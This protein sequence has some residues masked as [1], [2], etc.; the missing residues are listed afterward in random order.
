MLFTFNLFSRFLA[1]ATRKHLDLLLNRPLR[2]LKETQDYG[3][4]FQPGKDTWQLSGASDSDFAGDLGTS[5]STTG[6]VTKLGQYGAIVASS[7]LERKVST[8]TGQAETYA[9]VSLVK[10]IVWERHLLRELRH[11]QERPT[12]AA[13]DNDGVLNQSTKGVNH[14]TAKHYRVGQAYIRDNGNNETVKIETVDTADNAPD[15]ITKALDFRAFARHR[16]SIMGPQS[17]L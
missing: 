11:P 15:I 9:M 10:E 7:K 17:L 3:I 12:P 2:Y 5:R 16:D 14:S 6:Y 4:V 13:T 1:S 8:S